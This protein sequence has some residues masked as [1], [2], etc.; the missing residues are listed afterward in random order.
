MNMEDEGERQIGR[1]EALL[2]EVNEGIER[3]RWP[4]VTDGTV[5][6]RCECAL[7][8]CNQSVELTVPEYEEVR[9]HSRRFVVVPGHELPDAETVVTSSS[10]YVVVE[11]RAEAGAV[12][13]ELDPRG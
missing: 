6:F 8:D 1:N 7:L 11:K 10:G 2:R 9:D 4:T 13:E 12:A 3:G 5:R